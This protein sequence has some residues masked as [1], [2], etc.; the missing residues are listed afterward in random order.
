[1]AAVGAFGFCIICEV[2][3]EYPRALWPLRSRKQESLGTALCYTW[4]SSAQAELCELPQATKPPLGSMVER[5][6]RASWGNVIKDPSSCPFL[7][8]AV[9][10]ARE[11]LN[12]ACLA[13]PHVSH[14]PQDFLSPSRQLWFPAEEVPGGQPTL[15][16]LACLSSCTKCSESPQSDHCPES[17][18]DLW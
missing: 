11:R 15:C 8:P 7:S 13:G 10:G 18:E 3:R 14:Q 12:S 2:T 4:G 6:H 17:L 1:M 9:A 5:G 16:S